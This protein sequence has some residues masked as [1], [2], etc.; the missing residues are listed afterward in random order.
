MKGSQMQ[1]FVRYAIVVSA[2]LILGLAA[3][4]PIAAPTTAP[5]E[6]TSAGELCAPPSGDVL[7][8][9]VLPVLNTLP[10]FVAQQAGFY[11]ALGVNVEIVPVESARDRAI[12]QQAGEIDVANSDVIGTVL[13]VNGGHDV[14]IVR[15]DTFMPDYRFFSIVTGAASGITT[16]EDL[17]VALGTNEAQIAISQN[18]IIE[19]LAT[20]MLRNA[21]YEPEADDY[22]EIAAIPI[23]LEQ[24][25][26]GTVAA[27]LLPEPLTT[28][29]TTMQ[30]GTAVADDNGIDF[31]P[32][33]LTVNQSAIDRRSGDICAF[34][35]AYEMAVQAIAAD[36]EAYRENPI[37]IPD[38]L[39]ATYTIPQFAVPRVPD[40][41]EIQRVIDWMI[42]SG[43][44]DGGS[45][46]N[47]ATYENLVDGRFI[48]AMQAI[49][50]GE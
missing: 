8:I 35:K 47:T 25:A 30:G 34:L 5:L 1:K 31:I 9:G 20:T 2:I 14:R 33:A 26:Q 16:I 3:C 19:Y 23:R 50:L 41:S 10:I 11:D 48:E 6:S 40:E 32:V 36:P 44:V 7:K 29:A 42:D 24:I 12:A 39:R 43:L 4:T 45:I 13:Q 46:S 17:I 49:T 28:L 37:R 15:H 18:T 22:L 21:G 38:P 27:G